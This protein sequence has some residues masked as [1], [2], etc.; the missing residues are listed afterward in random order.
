MKPM[1]KRIPDQQKSTLFKDAKAFQ[2]FSVNDL[3]KAK[4][5]YGQTLGLEVSETPEGLDVQ[6]AGGKGYLS[7]LSRITVPRPSPSSIS[8]SAILRQRSKSSAD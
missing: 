2:S 7:I 5:F 3:Q 8:W 4:Q 6:I 1:E